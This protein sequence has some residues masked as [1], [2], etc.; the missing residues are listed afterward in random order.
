MFG[1]VVEILEQA[2]ENWVLVKNSFDSYEGYMDPKQLLKID[3]I[4]F[5]KFQN[6]QLTNKKNVVLQSSLGSYLLPAGCSFPEK[7]FNV[8]NI[9]FS[10]DEEVCL[11]ETKDS[12]EV[13]ELA[14]S[15]LNTP[16]LWGGKSSY[17]LDCSGFTQTVFKMA[18]IKLL[19]D[20]SQQSTQGELLNF[21]E[22]AQPGDLAFFDNEEGEIIHVGIILSHNE[23]IHASGRVRI[24]QLDHQGIFN[25]EL[26]KYTHNLRL[27]KHF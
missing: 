13:S 5:V 27:I 3:S 19:R 26:G 9:N 25:K 7:E 10:I 1:D 11:A 2:A 22:E 16:Y 24:D 18:G 12:K 21:I 14:L 15:F 17:G 6:L 4:D 8:G 20:A 23:I